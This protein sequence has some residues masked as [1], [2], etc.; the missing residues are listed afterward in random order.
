MPPSETTQTPAEAAKA[1]LLPFSVEQSTGR[2]ESRDL[3]LLQRRKP[4]S[5][6]SNTLQGKLIGF[7][8]SLRQSIS[9]LIPSRKSA[10]TTPRPSVYFKVKSRSSTPSSSTLISLI[11]G[12][13][14]RSRPAA[15]ASPGSQPLSRP[16][17]D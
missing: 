15:S 10:V 12:F 17:T 16:P 2:P 7:T 4:S 13:V 8:E 14:K 3:W 9:T 11:T 5:T 1:I 6:P